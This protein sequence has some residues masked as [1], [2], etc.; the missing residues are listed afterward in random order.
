MCELA[1]YPLSVSLFVVRIRCSSPNPM[2]LSFPDGRP[3]PNF[4]GGRYTH[5][6]GKF[7][8]R[9]VSCLVALLSIPSMVV[10]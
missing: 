4:F 7:N 8:R 10:S 1:R 6:F 3:R 5:F 2:A 9:P